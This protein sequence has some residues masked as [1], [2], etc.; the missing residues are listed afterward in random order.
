MKGI[1]F[2]MN[3]LISAV[4]SL[5]PVPHFWEL[6]PGKSSIHSYSLR[7]IKD[8]RL[9]KNQKDSNILF[10]PIIFSNKRETI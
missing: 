5:K 2:T 10:C 3:L 8:S 7:S 4:A 9:E 1:F 6:T